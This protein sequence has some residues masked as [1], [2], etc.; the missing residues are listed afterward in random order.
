MRC[1]CGSGGFSTSRARSDLAFAPPP[2]APHVRASA[3][4]AVAENRGSRQARHDRGPFLP[5]SCPLS[6]SF[7]LF[8]PLLPSFALFFPIRSLHTRLRPS[9]PLIWP[10][11]ALLCAFL[12]PIGHIRSL[13]TRRWPYSAL[14]GPF[15]PYSALFG[16]I[17]RYSALFGPIRSY[18]GPAAP[19]YSA[20]RPDFAFFGSWLLP[21]SLLI[22]GESPIS[23]L[24]DL[25]KEKENESDESEENY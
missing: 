19:F 8:C 22:L 7:A 21:Y 6:P 20:R 24:I 1:A 13:P 17:R 11:P 23:I 12:A 10:L 9:S 15:W 5:L 16:P 18:F 25:K 2:L 3:V 4:Q 14:F